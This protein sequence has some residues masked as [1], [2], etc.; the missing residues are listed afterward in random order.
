MAYHKL[1]WKVTDIEFE[2]SL[3]VCDTAEGSPG[4]KCFCKGHGRTGLTVQYYAL[5]LISR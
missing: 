1:A 2:N 3:G 5:D 4:D